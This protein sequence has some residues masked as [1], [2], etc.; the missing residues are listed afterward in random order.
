MSSQGMGKLMKSSQ[1][2][3]PR[4]GRQSAE[5]AE[6]TKRQIL[7]AALECFA[8][9]GFTNTTLRDIAER[10]NTT[11]GLPRH[12]FGSKEELWKACA[13]SV[14]EQ[15]AELQLPALDSVTPETAL[16]SF[17][18]VVRTFILSAATY[19]DFWRLVA[20]EGLKG[21]ERLDY[22]AE[23]ALPQHVRIAELFDMVREQGYFEEY[24]NNRFF[25]SLVCLGALPFALSPL[26]NNLCGGDILEEE[27][28]L[29]HV[30]LVINT[31]FRH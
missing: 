23:L 28:R 22:L 13:A 5:V 19:P 4:S 21:G 11:H 9:H 25:L 30:E 12:H 20:S 14:V 16:E 29:R 2:A 6:R 10:A 24:D 18:S 17:E 1:Q 31:L 15:V 8:N 27:A 3:S 26:T 7:E